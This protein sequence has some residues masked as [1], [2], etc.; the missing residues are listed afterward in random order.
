MS[1]RPFLLLAAIICLPGLVP[2]VVQGDA[3]DKVNAAI[4]QLVGGKDAEKV[5]ALKDIAAMGEEGKPAAR[6]VA[7]AM[8]SKNRDIQKQAIEAFGKIE[9]EMLKPVLRL[10]LEKEFTRNDYEELLKSNSKAAIP[11]IRGRIDK[12]IKAKNLVGINEGILAL[13]TVGAGDDEATDSL[14][15]LST[16]RLEGITRDYRD[17]AVG[18]LAI[19]AATARGE[20]RERIVVGLEKILVAQQKLKKPRAKDETVLCV[21]ILKALARYGKDASRAAPTVKALRL[22]KDNA[23]RDAAVDALKAIE[24]E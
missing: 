6:A 12:D 22:D 14:I 11:L 3:D 15:R 16:Y 9:P 8:L 18:G 17:L 23:V 4:K 2:G 19:H 13:V 10:L 24:A 7:A 5:Q 20:Q 21:A 1:P